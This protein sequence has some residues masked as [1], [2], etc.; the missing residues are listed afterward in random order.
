MNNLRDKVGELIYTN[1][2]T[3]EG[4]SIKELVDLFMVFGEHCAREAYRT[5]KVHEIMKTS[6]ED[7]FIKDYF[8]K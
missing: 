5:G 8:S 7:Q 4:R 6:N 3:V 2:L 1:D